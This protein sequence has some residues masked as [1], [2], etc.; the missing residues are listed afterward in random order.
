MAWIQCCW[1]LWLAAAAL[2]QPLAQKLLYVMDVALKKKK[3]LAGTFL[4][5][6]AFGFGIRVMVASYSVLESVPSSSVFWESF[7]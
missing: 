5:G 1:L 3:V 7:E 6:S 4:F 2:I